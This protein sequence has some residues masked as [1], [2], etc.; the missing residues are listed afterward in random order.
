[1]SKGDNMET[2]PQSF[3]AQVSWFFR[4]TST[5]KQSQFIKLA[6]SNAIKVN[7]EIN[8]QFNNGD[9]VTGYT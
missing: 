5:A 9:S 8:T 4:E 7:T 2:R 1:M 6:V 3:E